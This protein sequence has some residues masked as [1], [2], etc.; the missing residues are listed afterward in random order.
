MHGAGGQLVLMIIAIVPAAG[1]S[2]RMGVQK[3]LLPFAGTTVIGH[4]VDE[5]QRSR[6]DEVCVVAGHQ[7]DRLRQALEGRAVRIV[8]NPDYE[9]TDMLASIR[10]GL[11]AMPADCRAVLVALGDQ[12]A[13]T[14]ELVDA[15]IDCFSSGEPGNRRAGSRRPAGASALAR[16]TVPQRNPDRLRSGRPARS[17]GRARRR[18]VRASGVDSAVLSDMDYPEDYQRELARLKEK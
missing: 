18:R 12:P 10:C 6:I 17:A 5:L 15:M 1:Q 9:R 11:A 7:A 16:R 14:A 4:I 3:Q 2:R 8:V 13:I